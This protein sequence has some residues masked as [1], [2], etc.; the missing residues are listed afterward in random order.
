MY[1]KNINLNLYKTFYDVAKSESISEAAKKTFTSQPAISKSI[2]KLEET[3][4]VKLFYRNLDGIKLTS[5]GE[6][7]LFYVEEAFNNLLVGERNITENEKL[8]SGKLTIG[9]PSQIG[10]FFVFDSISKFHKIYPNIEITIISSSTKSLLKKLKLHEIDFIID[11]SPINDVQEDVIIRPLKKVDNCFIVSKKYEDKMI[12]SLTYTLTSIN[13][14]DSIKLLVDGKELKKLPNSNKLLPTFLDKSYGINKIYEIT[15]VGNIDSYTVYFVNNVNDNKYYIPVTKYVN[16]YK[17]DKI[18]I[19]IDE[20]ASS[21]TYQSNLSSFLNENTKLLNY[22]V[23][24]K[25]IKLNFNDMIFSD[26]TNNDILEEVVYTIC[27][28]INDS[29]DIDSVVFLANDREILKK[30]ISDLK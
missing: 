17:Q 1:N 22:E 7:L 30:N 4:N 27:L 16:D 3:L 6:K 15:N 5:E 2:K 21:F 13:G 19:I 18:R 28:S 11:S 10:T 12:E 23:I 25:Q 14:I 8:Q 24:D 26:I 9:V 20:L 29:I